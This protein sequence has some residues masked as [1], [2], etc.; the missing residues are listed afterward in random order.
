MPIT[1]KNI[2]APDF[3]S[4]NALM[5]AG[6]ES[7]TGG[8]DSLAKA[9][10]TYGTQQ[11]DQR[12]AIRDDNTQTFLD[13]ID[14]MKTMDG[15]NNQADQFSQS[16]LSGQNVDASAIMSAYGQQ[17]GDIRDSIIGDNSFAASKQAESERL[18]GIAEKPFINEI[19]ALIASGKTAEA[20]AMIKANPDAVADTSGL[21]NAITD[22]ERNNLK[23]DQSQTLYDQSQEADALRVNQ[24]AQTQD[25]ASIIS[26]VVA[27]SSDA[28]SARAQAQQQLRFNG[29][30]GTQLK[31]AM[32][33]VDNQFNQYH[34]LSTNQ[35]NNLT[36]VTESTNQQYDLDSKVLDETYQRALTDIP[37]DEK[38]AFGN[39]EK[40]TQADGVAAVML[41]APKPTTVDTVGGSGG[42]YL[43]NR[44]TEHILPIL[45]QE[46]GIKDFEEVP[47]II[48]K[49]AAKEMTTEN[50]WLPGGDEKLNSAT[51]E[52]RAKFWTQAYKESEKNWLQQ[53][54]LHLANN[55]DQQNLLDNKLKGPAELLA[56]YKKNNAAKLKLTANK[57]K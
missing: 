40:F 21:Y 12:V 51:L 3:S 22:A 8:L 20:T 7:M 43:S 30:S 19:N 33:D 17:K 46:L 2:N 41:L 57:P 15:Y 6:A 35:S 29:I 44:I 50:E 32:A 24:N 37:V 56:Q 42:T 34:K 25:A 48:L 23:F 38:F 28:I 14:Q 36:A 4:G 1:W 45:R 55:T 39:P 16:A 5:K 47:G 11:E 54:E 26:Q 52:T 49:L 27:G 13:Q 10:K 9:A 18:R 31:N 53:E